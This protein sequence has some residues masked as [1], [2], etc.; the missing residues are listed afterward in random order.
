M[1][2][3]DIIVGVLAILFLFKGFKK[4][5]F[6]ELAGFV[7]LFSGLWLAYSYYEFFSTAYLA[8]YFEWSEES[9]Q[10]FSF[11]ILFIVVVTLV[12]LLAKLITR[13]LKMIALGLVNRLFG[14]LFGLLKLFLLLIVFYFSLDYIDSFYALKSENWLEDSLVFQNTFGLYQNYFPTLADLFE[15]H[16]SL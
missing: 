1:N 11:F 2:I 15:E 16:T 3:F 4:G 6:N 12:H 5:L 14:G 13:F 10:V 9:L 7:A 8:G